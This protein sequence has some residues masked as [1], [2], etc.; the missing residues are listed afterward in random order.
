MIRATLLTTVDCHLCRHA[1]EVL[2]RLG[3]EY[4]LHVETVDMAS[5]AGR[6]LARDAGVLFPPGLL[7]DD[8]LAGYGRLSE[9]RL[10]RD[11]DR[12]ASGAA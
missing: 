10:R 12:L 7:L 6:R 3:A 2:D 8:R 11:L 4:E 1:R 9:R 5:D